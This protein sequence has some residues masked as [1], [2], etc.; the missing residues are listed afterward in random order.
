VQLTKRGSLPLMARLPMLKGWKPSTSLSRL[1]ASRIWRSLMCLGRGSCTSM[2]CTAG[3]PLYPSTTWQ[4]FP[5]KMDFY[6][7]LRRFFYFFIFY[8]TEMDDSLHTLAKFQR[9]GLASAFRIT[10][11]CGRLPLQSGIFMS[12]NGWHR[13]L[14]HHGLMDDPFPQPGI[15]SSKFALPTPRRQ[16]AYRQ[17][18]GIGVFNH[19]EMDEPFHNIHYLNHIIIIIIIFYYFL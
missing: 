1:M 7:W 4:S 10:E 17:V 19:G 5:K 12:D 2:P 18:V 3:S 9:K 15:V 8:Y 14:S 13:R 6:G 11:R 16:S